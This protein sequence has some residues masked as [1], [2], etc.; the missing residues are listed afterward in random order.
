EEILNSKYSD[1]YFSLAANVAGRAKN[2]YQLAQ[3]TLP[4]EDRKS[5]V[6]AELMGSVYWR[7]LQKLEHNKFNVFTA[8]PLKLS[9]PHK[10]A[11]IFQ[12]WLRFTIGSTSSNYGH[13]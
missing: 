8:Q 5:M 7:L 9:K 3:K 10:L 13:A 2:F 12:S 11:L 4:L 1:R 6:A